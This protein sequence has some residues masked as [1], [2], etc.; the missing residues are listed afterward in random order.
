MR[1][2]HD[3]ED[4][5]AAHYFE[6]AFTGWAVSKFARGDNLTVVHAGQFLYW[7]QWGS[8]YQ[9]PR[10]GTVIS[11]SEQS[12]RVVPEEGAAEAKGDT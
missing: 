8:H 6:D 10:R 5:A 1:A 4:G 2:H 9:G 11:L 7:D 12:A 3:E